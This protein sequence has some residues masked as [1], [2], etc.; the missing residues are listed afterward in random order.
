MEENNVTVESTE[1]IEET[2]VTE[3]QPTKKDLLREISKDLG[4]NAF[5]PS[6]VKAKF[7]EFN[8]WKE[9]QKTEQEKL[10]EQVNTYQTQLE[11]YQKEIQQYEAKLKASELGI[12]TSKLEDAL[13]LADYDTNK[14]NDVVKKYPSFLASSGVKIGLGNQSQKPPTSNTEVEAFMAN[15]PKYANYLKTKK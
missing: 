13:K 6:E 9:S 5:E 15:D 10:A 11:N 14:L 2:T 12:D 8:A 4:I 7:D 1:T 3:Q